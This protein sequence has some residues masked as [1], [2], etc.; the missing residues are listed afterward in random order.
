[1]RRYCGI[2]GEFAP[3]AT[4][5]G[6]APLVARA[7]TDRG[8]VYFFTT[9]ASP[10][11]STLATNGVA[12]YVA[13]QRVLGAGAAQLSNARQL[14]AGEAF[15]RSK[16]AW[17]KLA[18]TAE[19]LSTEYP[20]HAGVYAADKG[21]LAVNRTAAEDRPAV[22]SDSRVAEL[23]RGLDFD[24]LDDQAGNVK[25]LAREI[26]RMCVG[27]MMVAIVVEA[28][29]CLPRPPRKKGEAK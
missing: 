14:A 11:D 5:Y 12:L 25:S 29:L 23:F 19:A 8:G 6:G 10:N 9:T 21:I 28:G 13:I 2:A 22:L 7:T 24:R 1:M 18:G 27:A 3:I 26:W 16:D 15:P 4:L 17:R 20:D